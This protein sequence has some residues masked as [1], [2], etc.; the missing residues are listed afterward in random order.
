M[1]HWYVIYTRSRAEK[2]TA[3]RLEEAGFEVYCPMREEMRQWSDRIKK[4][5]EPVFR[6]YVFIR[7]EHYSK[8]SIT[9][10]NTPGVVRFLWWLGKPAIARDV[11]IEQIRQFLTEYKD[12]D[13]QITFRKGE[14]VEIKQGPFKEFK[15]II[16]DLDQRKAILEIKSLGLALKA[17]LSLGVLKKIIDKP[18]D[19]R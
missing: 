8:E 2:K 13:I 18:D 3:T 7:L 6:S 11:E 14:E 12:N 1:K 5:K 9:V 15:G 19:S 4:V 17:Q 16:I 10:L